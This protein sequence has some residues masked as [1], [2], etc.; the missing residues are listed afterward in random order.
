MQKVYRIYHANS[1]LFQGENF[2]T[3]KEAVIEARKRAVVS[4][5]TYL[6]VGIEA[7]V[8]TEVVQTVHLKVDYAEEPTCTLRRDDHSD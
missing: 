7:K 8:T 1:G 3:V 4:R 5:A 2:S 6:I